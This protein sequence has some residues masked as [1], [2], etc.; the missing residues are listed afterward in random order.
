M[1]EIAIRVATVAVTVLVMLL[2]AEGMLR[3]MPSLIG[4]AVL[5][6][7]H[8]SLR[9]EIAGRLGLATQADRLI[10]ASAERADKGPDLALH[11]PNR[12][13]VRPVDQPDAEIGGVEHFDTDSLGF[14]NP[15]G[16]AERRPIH[17][18]SI[19]GS[20]PNCT[21]VV[22]A[23]NYTARLGEMLGINAYNLAVPGVGPYEYLETLR[24]F[25]GGLAPK[26]VVM[27]I[28]E[29]NDLRDIERFHRFKAR[30]GRPRKDAGA[31]GLFAASYALA[32][33]KG[34]VEVAI[35][36]L[37]DSGGA[38]FRYS[39]T[40]QGRRVPL[41][42]NNGDVD[43]LKLAQQIEQ[44]RISP[45]L[46]EDSVA[47]FAALSRQMGF[48]P[49]VVLVPAAYTTYAETIEYEDAAITAAMRRYSDVQRQWFADNSARLGVR[50]FDATARMRELARE[51]PLLFFPSNVHLTAEGHKALAEAVA[52]AVRELLGGQ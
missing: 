32:F 10:V 17:V 29:S 41:N 25:G 7:F 24:R 16:L 18:A 8:P 31:G 43:E 52:P 35:R 1:R 4:V 12:R 20:I 51:R 21:A 26:I 44:G 9:T 46:Y 3:L 5:E 38:N 39:V 45:R 15:P 34:G 42:V 33:L 6:R 13:Y 49:L 36:S 14:C 23:D 30:D 40:V 22:A 37:R 11:F 2:L 47:A 50:Y 27:T 28:A 19:G 48:V